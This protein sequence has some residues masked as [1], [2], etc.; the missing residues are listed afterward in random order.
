MRGLFP[1]ESFS[2]HELSQLDSEWT[3]LL[4]MIIL[5]VHVTCCC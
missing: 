3:T 2:G 4:M 1:E 5:F